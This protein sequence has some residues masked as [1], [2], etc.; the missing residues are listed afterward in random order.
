MDR[1]K[2]ETATVNS[3]YVANLVSLSV[4]LLSGVG[5]WEKNPLATVIEI[6][7]KWVGFLS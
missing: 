2:G 4:V 3:V 5:N 6:R 7:A 1:V